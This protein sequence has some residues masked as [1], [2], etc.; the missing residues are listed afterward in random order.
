MKKKEITKAVLIL[1]LTFLGIGSQNAFAQVGTSLQFN[2][3]VLITWD[4]PASPWQSPV[5]TV[6]AGKVWKIESA[7]GPCDVEIYS[8]N[9]VNVCCI[10]IGTMYWDSKLPLWLPENTAIQFIEN[11]GGYDSFVSLIEFTVVP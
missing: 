6:P 3:V 1:C 8:I 2:Q 11:C 4:V 7:G 10:E 9:G 5:Y